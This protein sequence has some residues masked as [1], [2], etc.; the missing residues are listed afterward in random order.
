[1]EIGFDILATIPYN[2]TIVHSGVIFRKNR[3]SL[4]EAAAFFVGIPGKKP[5]MLEER[6]HTNTHYGG[7][8]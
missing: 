6:N 2:G 4:F 7:N 5:D 1:M 3:S 8:K